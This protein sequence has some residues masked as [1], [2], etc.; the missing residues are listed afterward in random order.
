MRGE[1]RARRGALQGLAPA[2]ALL[3]RRYWWRG[4]AWAVPLWGLVAATAPS[5]RDTYPSLASRSSLIEAMRAT[6]GTRLLYGILPRPGR[7][8]QLLAWETGTYLLVCTALMAI[9]LTCQMMR[10]DEERGLAELARATGCGGAVPFLAPW[11][12]VWGGS[13]APGRRCRRDPHG[14]GGEHR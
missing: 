14:G 9:L 10:G 6:P 12:A 8:G 1:K 4:A 5:Y 11:M 7:L 2:L 3:A 13:G